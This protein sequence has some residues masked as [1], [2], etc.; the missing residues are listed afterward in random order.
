MFQVNAHSEIGRNLHENFFI[1]L[2]KFANRNTFARGV[3]LRAA[4]F[5]PERY[6]FISHYQRQRL[7]N[8]P[9]QCRRCQNQISADKTS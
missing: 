1:A 7:I 3:Q 6:K 2:W 9:P 8:S 5:Y 4:N